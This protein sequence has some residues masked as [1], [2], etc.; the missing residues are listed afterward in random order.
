MY[1][2]GLIAVGIISLFL[3]GCSTERL[4]STFSAPIE[5]N[6][7]IQPAPLPPVIES[8]INLYVVDPKNI[9]Q[10]SKIA[11]KDSRTNQIVLMTVEDYQKWLNNIIE[12]QGYVE[13]L[14]SLVLY[15]EN[16]ISKNQPV[17]AEQDNGSQEQNNLQQE[18][19]QWG[20]Y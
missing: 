1:L 17:E 9:D 13:S 7:P 8:D 2:R 11:F 6:I 3:G 15:Y 18:S 19:D 10:K 14:N 12:I 4:I 20:E 16:S 5:I